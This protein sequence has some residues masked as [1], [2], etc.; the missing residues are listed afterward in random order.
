MPSVGLA[1]MAVAV[2]GDLAAAGAAAAGSRLASGGR[3]PVPGPG[4]R[5]ATSR[6][7]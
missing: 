7:A 6:G 2:S 1:F 4:N 3:F 5:A